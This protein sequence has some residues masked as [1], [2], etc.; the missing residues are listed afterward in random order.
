M[1]ILYGVNPMDG[2]DILHKI[3]SFLKNCRQKDNNK[4]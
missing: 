1:I 3:M 2:M 4:Y